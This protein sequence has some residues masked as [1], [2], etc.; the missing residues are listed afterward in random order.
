MGAEPLPE[1]SPGVLPLGV[2]GQEG[3]PRPQNE[4]LP[5]D[6][7]SFRMRRVL[8]FADVTGLCIAWLLSGVLLSALDRAS[9]TTEEF[10]LFLAFLPLWVLL[11]VLN[12]LYHDSDR[13]IDPSIADE[14][15]RLIALVTAWTWGYL[16]VRG[17]L[18][19]G[20]NQLLPAVLLWAAVIGALLLARPIARHLAHSRP[21]YWQN[22]VIVGRDTDVERVWR[23]LM[24]HP[25]YGLRVVD[26]PD[27][28]DVVSSKSGVEL[29]VKHLEDKRAA[30]VIVATPPHS[31]EHRGHLIRRLRDSGV[32][33]DLAT[34]IADSFAPSVMLNYLEAIP[35]VS[36]PKLEHS[37]AARIMKRLFD[38][39]GATTA[40]LVLSP[41]F[42]YC[43]IRIK[44][45]S[46][47]PTLF[48]QE[49]IGKKGKKFRVF[50]FRSMVVDAESQVEDLLAEADTGD[51]PALFKLKTDPRITRFGAVIRRWSLDEL[52]QLF[53][54]VLGDM[55]LVG[56]RPLPVEEVERVTAML[57]E[58]R[59]LFETRSRVLPGLTGTW[60]AHG[61]SDIGFEDMVQL[62]YTYV[63]NWSFAEDLKLILRTVEVILH[64]RGAY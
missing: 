29:L 51:S 38:V 25:E 33:V 9:A 10:L 55:S 28:W 45:D 50:K 19:S 58:E 56:P 22:V 57:G 30:R 61:R 46:P 64:G 15:G 34:G 32:Q 62:D 11:G 48:R 43:A 17:A 16:L 54:V 42:A 60:Q 1:G 35:V 8:A 7:R 63:A 24:R 5:A 49:R 26:V 27:M 3:V 52:P 41:V 53:N 6:S 14:A 20:A 4:I 2:V 59:E 37:K 18:T 13:R 12:G 47:G 23:R 31:V 40:L 36:V 21:W 44:L 39:V